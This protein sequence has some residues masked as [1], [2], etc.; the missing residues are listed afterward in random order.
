M[1]DVP[2]VVCT[3]HLYAGRGVELFVELARRFP[4]LNFL[5]VGGQ[6][7]DV[8]GWRKRLLSEGLSN[9]T[10][11]GFVENSQLPRYQAAADVLLMPYER[12]IAGSGGGNSAAYCS[13]MKMFEYMACGRAIISSDLPVI[14]E[15][16]NDHNAVLCPPE[17]LAGWVQALRLLFDNPAV[18]ENLARQAFEDVQGYTWIE[19]Q[20]KA[21][22]GFGGSS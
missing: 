8:E 2:T 17:D 16:L 15:V 4:H 22:E 10:L 12:V 13:P 20:R 11:T 19:R 9:L 6:P 14:R 7:E 21:M 5:W 18:R 1:S 3:G